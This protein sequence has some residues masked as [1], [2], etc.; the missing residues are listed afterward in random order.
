MIGSFVYSDPVIRANL[1]VGNSA[2]AI[3]TN[4]SWAKVINN[5]IVFNGSGV[6]GYGFYSSSPTYKNCIIWGNGDDLT[7]T[8]NAT[9]SC[10]QDGDAGAGNISSDPLLLILEM[11]TIIY[12]RFLLVSMLAIQIQSI[13]MLRIQTIKVMLYSL[14][15]ELLEMIWGALVVDKTII[16]GINKIIL[17]YQHH[18]LFPKTILIHLIQR[19]Q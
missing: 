10:I 14:L 17:F 5:T 15:L 6:D 3:E 1:F 4:N 19:Q 2:Q 8:A 11:V 18:F 7:R 12:S 9:Y 13:M 16:V